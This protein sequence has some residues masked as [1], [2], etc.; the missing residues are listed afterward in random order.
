M[1]RQICKMCKILYF[2]ECARLLTDAGHTNILLRVGRKH[3]QIWFVNTLEKSCRIY[4][5]Y[6]S[7]HWSRFFNNW[8]FLLWRICCYV[9]TS[10]KADIRRRAIFLLIIK[11]SSF[12]PLLPHQPEFAKTTKIIRGKRI[13]FLSQIFYA[14]QELSKIC[15]DNKT[16][17][18]CHH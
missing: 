2:Q 3:S 6:V 18:K 4:T 16:W 14:L 9:Y 15:N 1:W 17:P 13:S 11:L 10:T 12:I 7:L 5:A 8:K